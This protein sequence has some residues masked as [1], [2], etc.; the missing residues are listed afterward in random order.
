MDRILT[1]ILQTLEE[2]R[3]QLAAQF[4]D[5]TRQWMISDD[6]DLGHKR[7][8]L[9]KRLRVQYFDLDPLIRGRCGAERNASQ[10]LGKD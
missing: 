10:T 7:D 6:I 2:Q 4:E 1:A 8:T 3:S 5:M 9:A